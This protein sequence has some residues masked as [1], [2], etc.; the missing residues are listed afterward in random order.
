MCNSK[1]T[2]T[3]D[4]FPLSLFACFAVIVER[5]GFGFAFMTRTAMSERNEFTRLLTTLIRHRFPFGRSLFLFGWLDERLNVREILCARRGTLDWHDFEILCLPLA[6]IRRLP[7][8]KKSNFS[9]EKG[10]P[11]MNWLRLTLFHVFSLR[12]SLSRSAFA[13]EHKTVQLSNFSQRS[14]LART[15]VE[16]IDIR[17]KAERSIK[18]RWRGASLS[19]WRRENDWVACDAKR[20]LNSHV[21]E[22]RAYPWPP[23]RVLS[24]NMRERAGRTGWM[25]LPAV[26]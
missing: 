2:W 9:F 7:S 4:I 10:E 22:F 6:R 3:A 1:V 17:I 11:V 14:Q 8:E 26:T 16:L 5:G 24:A 21:R 12:V 13:R 18:V 15:Y 23:N 19:S 25:R 20:I